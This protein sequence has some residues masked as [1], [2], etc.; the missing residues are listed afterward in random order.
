MENPFEILDQRLSNIE[1]KLDNLMS[2]IDNQKILIEKVG[3][4]HNHVH[5]L[6]RLKNNQD[7]RPI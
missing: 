7:T 4:F 6:F 1:D 5:C 3:G 2:R